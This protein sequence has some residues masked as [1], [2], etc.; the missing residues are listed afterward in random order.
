MSKPQDISAVWPPFTQMKTAKK[1][2]EIVKAK[3]TLLTDKNGKTYIDANS[4]WWVNVHGHGNEYLLKAIHEQ[5][6]KVDHVLLAGVTHEKAEELAQRIIKILPGDFSKVFFSDDGSTAIEVALKMVFQYWHNQGK[7]KHRIVALEGAYHGDTFGAMSIG[8][9]GYFNEPFEHLFFGVD[10]LPFPNKDLESDI[11]HQANKLFETGEIAGLILEPLVQGSAGM[12]MYSVEF[13]DKLLALAKKQ[14]VLVIFD[15]IM[16]GWGRTGKMFSMNHAQEI[17]DIVCVSK[18]LTGGVLPMGL[19][20]TTD[21][22]YNAFLHEEKTKALLHGHSY[23]GNPLACAVAC[24]SMDLFEQQETWNHIDRIEKSHQ[25]FHA[26]WEGDQRL[27]DIRFQGTILAV[28]LKT[29]EES[30]YFSNIRDIAYDFF[31][32]KGILLRPLG[33]VIFLNPPFCITEK[34]LAYCYEKIE[35][36]LTQLN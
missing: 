18:G 14:D 21:K 12:R 16:T 33:N 36:F 10:T 17:P 30:S 2:L 13:M 9:R 7:P 34:E 3:G 28:E 19:T 25:L 32:E 20:V 26:K 23:T 24:A 15:E 4:S 31:L 6:E 27:K 1:P 22:I 5:F 29:G 8:Q 11:L 35:E